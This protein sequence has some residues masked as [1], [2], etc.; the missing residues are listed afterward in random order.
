MGKAG[1]SGT[2][3]HEHITEQRALFGTT[4]DIHDDY[5]EEAENT[6]ENLIH[7][8]LFLM[9]YKARYQDRKEHKRAVKDR[10]VDG[11]CPRHT[12][13]QQ[14]I[15]PDG[16]EQRQHTRVDDIAF[17][18]EHQ[19]SL[20][21]GKHGKRH[22][23]AENEARPSKHQN[24]AGVRGCDGELAVAELYEDKVHSPHHTY[25]YCKS[26]AYPRDREPASG[27]VRHCGQFPRFSNSSA[28]SKEA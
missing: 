14:H 7:A 26:S 27:H 3:Q 19:L 25:E 17:P 12:E 16:L 18:E 11:A 23:A 1:K 9:K 6:A 8:E 5:S 15:L 24:T 10:S 28:S 20:H 13:I 22:N 2:Q 21:G 4:A